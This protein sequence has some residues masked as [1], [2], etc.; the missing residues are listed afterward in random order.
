M[1]AH[2]GT[3][4]ASNPSRQR[5]ALKWEVWVDFRR[6]NSRR[7]RLEEIGRAAFK[8]SDSQATDEAR[9]E[10]RDGVGRPGV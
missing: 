8:L 6:E 5:R 7:E 2:H 3:H 4:V 10:A 9:S 1:R